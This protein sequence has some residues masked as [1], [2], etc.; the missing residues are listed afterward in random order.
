MS[1]QTERE[2]VRREL[3][4]S[5]ANPAVQIAEIVAELENTEPTRLPTMYDCV[6]GMLDNLFSQPPSPEAQM[7]VE[8]SYKSYRITVEQDATA[9][10]VKTG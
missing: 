6:D 9:T 3:D 4:Q 8:F 2:I 5:A 1:D 7:A 10:F